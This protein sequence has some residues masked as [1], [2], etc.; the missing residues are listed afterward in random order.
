MRELFAADLKNK[1][2]VPCDVNEVILV[3]YENNMSNPKVKFETSNVF[4]VSDIYW[5]T[6]E[7]EWILEMPGGDFINSNFDLSFNRLFIVANL[8]ELKI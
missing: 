2:K 6:E 1:K 7:N 8:E 4:I 3:Y 5:D